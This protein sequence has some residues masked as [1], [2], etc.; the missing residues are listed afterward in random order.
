MVK[1]L[2]NWRTAPSFSRILCKVV[3]RDPFESFCFVIF[4]FSLIIVCLPYLRFIYT[5][6]WFVYLF[7][8]DNGQSWLCLTKKI[9]FI[10]K[11]KEKKQ[12]KRQI[13]RNF[14]QKCPK[15]KY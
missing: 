14:R 12:T 2:E 6:Y 8:I 10:E 3:G 5:N 11:T 4:F 1:E 9:E 15:Y 7:I 13:N